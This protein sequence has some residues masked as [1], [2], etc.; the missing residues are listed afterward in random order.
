MATT[1]VVHE[2][3]PPSIAQCDKQ[4]EHNEA[5]LRSVAGYTLSDDQRMR[6]FQIAVERRECINDAKAGPRLTIAG[7]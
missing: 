6:Y 2:K 5:V 7:L 4:A 1:G 3:T